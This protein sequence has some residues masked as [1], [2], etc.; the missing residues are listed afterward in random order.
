M[1]FQPGQDVTI[2]FDGID[3]RG[4]II[5]HRHGTIMAVIQTDPTAD[6]GSGTD[7][8]APQQTVCVAE[9]KVKP[10]QTC[11]TPDQ[12]KNNL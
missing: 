2:E 11:N 3:H 5:E 9:H 1:K 7:R 8:L 12:P 10:A 4:H 6:Y